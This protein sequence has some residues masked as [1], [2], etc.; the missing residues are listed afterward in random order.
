[1]VTPYVA[2]DTGGTWGAAGADAVCTDPPAPLQLLPELIN[3]ALS[4]LYVFGLLLF[5]ADAQKFEHCEEGEGN[6]TS[7]SEL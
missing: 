3:A 5:F 4:I 2:N 1:L 7:R 6:V